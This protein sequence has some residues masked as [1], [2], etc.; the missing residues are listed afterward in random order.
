MLYFLVKKF[1]YLLSFIIKKYCR[2]IVL[3]L[4]GIESAVKLGYNDQLRTDQ[5]C[6]L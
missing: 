1:T 2:S 6:S 5:I 3:I 4:I